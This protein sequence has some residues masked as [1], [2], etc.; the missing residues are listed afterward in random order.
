MRPSESCTH[1]E[2]HGFLPVILNA[3]GHHVKSDRDEPALLRAEG[4][5]QRV[6]RSA[7]RHCDSPAELNTGRH[8][9]VPLHAGA[10]VSEHYEL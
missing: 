6:C 3:D 5:G 9:R 7:R 1:I 4:S 2:E 8:H 10:K